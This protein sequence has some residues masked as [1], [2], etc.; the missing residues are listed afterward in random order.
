M[1]QDSYNLRYRRHL[2]RCPNNKYKIHEI[3]IMIH[4]SIMESRREILAE[5]CDIRL[6]YSRSRNIVIFIIRA[7]FVVLALLPRTG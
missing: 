1:R 4:Q 7:I 6:H 2:Q 5:E 3:S